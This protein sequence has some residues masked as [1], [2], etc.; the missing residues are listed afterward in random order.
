MADALLESAVREE[1]LN[2]EEIFLMASSI[3]LHDIGMQTGWIEAP[4][5]KGAR[6]FLSPGDRMVIRKNHAKTTGRVIRSFKDNL[7]DWLDG[8]L[9]SRQKTIVREDLNEALAFTCESHNKPDLKL[10]L[11]KEI[12]VLFPGT[13]LKIGAIAAMLQ[14]C[15]GLHMDMSRL[16]EPVFLD[17][18]ERWKR[19]EPLEAD[20][21]PEDW[22]RFFQC[23]YVE[24]VSIRPVFEAGNLFRIV[25][26]YRFNR[27]E[28]PEIEENFLNIYARRLGKRRNDC[29]SV[30]NEELGIHFLNDDPFRRLEPNASKKIF[31][32]SFHHIL[33]NAP[34]SRAEARPKPSG[35]TSPFFRG[36]DEDIRL[37]KDKI[38]TFPNRIITLHGS[39]GVGKTELALALADALSRDFPGGC[40]FTP[41]EGVYSR[42]GLAARLRLE[43]GLGEG[44]GDRAILEALKSG[45]RLVILDNFEDPLKDKA[46]VARF[47][48]KIVAGPA[49]SRVILTTREALKEASMEVIHEVAE[50]SREDS[51]TL[52][53]ALARAQGWSGSSAGEGLD[54]LLDELAG[55]P[56][57]IELAAPYMRYGV[58]ALV[59]NLRSLGL[60]SLDVHGIDRAE[61][62][63]NQ[64]LNKSL[65][66]SY[67]TIRDTDAVGGFK[68]L[69]LFPAGAREA[70][71]AAVLPEF[72]QSSLIT[73]ET[74]SLIR[75]DEEGGYAMLAP[76][77]AY[78][79]ARLRED[80]GFASIR[81]RW[82]DY[83]KEKSVEYEQTTRGKGERGVEA[84][85]RAL[86]NM[87]KALDYLLAEG[88]AQKD[89]F[90][91]I[92]M[93]LVDF[94]LLQGLNEDAKR[95]LKRGERL[96]RDAGDIL[97]E[98][99]CIYKRGLVH[100]KESRSEDA[101]KSFERAL[102]LY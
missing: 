101:R 31:P 33:E 29:V 70:D 69:S 102:P 22:R 42:D 72:T 1:R 4:G 81:K 100:F 25:V 38:R 52:L 35:R 80:E 8:V 21:E 82:I 96:A 64:S 18:L 67:A 55:I 15:D 53:M 65:S 49:S 78:A 45:K 87:A 79:E 51:R 36:R 74:K 27:R 20:H 84:L 12:P 71:L 17:S 83:C 94:M 57:A 60:S 13:T 75:L 92:L 59:E 90:L 24:K 99:K 46:P 40:I 19:G 3:Q 54:P 76:I 6:G 88:G 10:R 50:L 95:H 43:L 98:A 89:P 62:T 9:N 11:E 32:E 48:K 66:L 5:V 39:P 26:A 63:K 56:L 2:A 91:E 30:I 58:G 77:R 73:L 86:P 14:L 61:A 41:L 93:N 34:A 23:Y 7:P 28:V 68:A 16:N 44:G 97:G 37:I 85:T 47:L